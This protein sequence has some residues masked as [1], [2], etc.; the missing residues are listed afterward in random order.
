MGGFHELFTAAA[1]FSLLNV[2]CWQLEIKNNKIKVLE[3][4]NK[5]KEG[6]S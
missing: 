3:N 1:I 2:C 5:I 4:N 6:A